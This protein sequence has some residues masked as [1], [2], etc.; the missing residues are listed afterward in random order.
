MGKKRRTRT[1]HRGVKLLARKLTNGKVVHV[2]RWINPDTG[3]PTQE[4]LTNLAKAI[5]PKTKH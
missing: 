3:K 5:P 2:A 4:S 1:D